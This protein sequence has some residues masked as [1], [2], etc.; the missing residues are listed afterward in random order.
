[1][2]RT[3]LIVEGLSNKKWQS[4]ARRPYRRAVRIVYWLR[5]RYGHDYF[6]AF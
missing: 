1:M 4:T 2:P 6:F 3:Y 5:K